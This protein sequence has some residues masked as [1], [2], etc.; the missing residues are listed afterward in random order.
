[1]QQTVESK[2]NIGNKIKVS[3]LFTGRKPYF[4]DDETQERNCY[5]VTVG[6]NGKSTK[7]TYGDSMADTEAGL[8]PKKLDILEI[9]TSDFY[10]NKEYYPTYKDF[11]SEFRYDEDSI[12]GSVVYEKC[13]KQGEKLHSVFSEDDIKKLREELDNNA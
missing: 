2:G 7:F 8:K 10:Y 3:F 9:I 6:Y 12:K 1:M 13:L 4:D 11:A 5:V